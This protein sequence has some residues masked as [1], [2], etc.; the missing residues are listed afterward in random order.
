[1]SKYTLSD[2]T[3]YIDGKPMFELS[4]N[5]SDSEGYNMRPVDLDT[6]AHV[7]V[8]LLNAANVPGTW[9]VSAKRDNMKSLISDTDVAR[10]TFYTVFTKHHCD[11]EGF[12]YGD[13]YCRE[14]KE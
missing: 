5:G 1:M 11:I 4:R 10:D 9:S 6:M 7:I 14:C 13:G 8:N 3:V 2:R 12:D